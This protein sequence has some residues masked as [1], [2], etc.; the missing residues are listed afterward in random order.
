MLRLLPA[1]MLMLGLTASAPWSVPV[2]Y[3][4]IRIESVVT[5]LDLTNP[6]HQQVG[7]LQFRGA[8]ELRSNDPAFG[9]VSSLRRTQ[10]GFM[11]VGDAGMLLRFAIGPGGAIYQA[12]LDQIA[13]GADR[14]DE[15]RERDAESLV[16]D[17]A[18]GRYWIGFEHS[19]MIRRYDLATG[20]ITAEATPKLMKDWPPNA[21]A[22]VMVRLD[23][24]RFLILSEDGGDVKHLSA[25][26]LF[27]GDPTAPGATAF[28]FNY[29][30]PTG[31]LVTDAAQLPDGRLLL[32]HR[33]FTMLDGVSAIVSLADPKTIRRGK[34]WTAQPIAHLAPPL[35]VD[36]MEG[37]EVTQERGETLVWLV[38]D[39]NFSPLQRTLLMKFALKLKGQV[40]AKGR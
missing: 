2:H 15:K 21:G 28:E 18:G 24:G 11:A 14:A 22:E 3:G 31:Y 20:K 29:R 12:R 8:W 35:A 26:V 4:Q 9:G 30:P 7:A 33:R 36:N 27:S 17:E 13:I 1:F 25:S 6:S 34:I 16:V 38:S 32:L 37:V 23:D 40:R 39:D 5:P 10:H 19:N